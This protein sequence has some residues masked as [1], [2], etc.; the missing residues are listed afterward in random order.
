MKT[1]I[2]TVNFNVLFNMNVARLN[3]FFVSNKNIP[4]LF[5]IVENGLYSNKG[6]YF[7]GIKWLLQDMDY[8]CYFTKHWKCG[9]CIKN[10]LINIS[11]Q[12]IKEVIEI[13]QFLAFE[14]P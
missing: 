11:Q 1:L 8:K 13:N 6:W 2:S 10:H 7:R 14:M 3:A 4:C 9:K 5:I 12:Y